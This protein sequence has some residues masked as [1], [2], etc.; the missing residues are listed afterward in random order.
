MV[1]AKLWGV[2]Y[3]TSLVTPMWFV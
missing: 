2:L 1:I 3:S